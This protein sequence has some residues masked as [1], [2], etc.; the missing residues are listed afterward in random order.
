MGARR[1]LGPLGRLSAVSD[2]SFLYACAAIAMSFAGFA[3]L[4]NALRPHGVPWKPVELY[5]LN[6]IVM[7]A[8]TALFSALGAVPLAAVLGEAGAVRV[9]AVGLL[10]ATTSFGVYQLITDVRLGK[11]TAVSPLFRFTVILN[12]V[13]QGLFA[14]AAVL[15][16]ALFAYQLALLLLLA[17]PALTFGYVVAHLDRSPS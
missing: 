14:L 13:L 5:R 10:A 1:V 12:G 4:I 16:A 9:L 8:F 11:S 7:Y 2:A 17:S 3:G 15:T 6:V